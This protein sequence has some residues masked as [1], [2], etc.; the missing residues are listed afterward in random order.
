MNISRRNLLK[1][2]SASGL[3]A[4][5]L[6]ASEGFFKPLLAQEEPTQVYPENAVAQGQTQSGDRIS[7]IMS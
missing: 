1:V 2:T 6:A 4:A 7:L 5:G 3:V